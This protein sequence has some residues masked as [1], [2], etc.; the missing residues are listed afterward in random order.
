MSHV[1]IANDNLKV[2]TT[3]LIQDKTYEVYE[4][5][6]NPEV[7]VLS[8]STWCWAIQ[9]QDVQV[10]RSPI[11]CGRWSSWPTVLSHIITSPPGS[12]PQYVPGLT[13]QE[14]LSKTVSVTVSYLPAMLT[15]GKIV[16]Q[17]CSSSHSC[18][19]Q[20]FSLLLRDNFHLLQEVLARKM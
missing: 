5:S 11:F 13:T 2:L 16:V 9:T 1:L 14:F 3:L 15:S 18:L 10:T 12:R 20:L 17:V 6:I 19:T 7:C 8:W 4:K